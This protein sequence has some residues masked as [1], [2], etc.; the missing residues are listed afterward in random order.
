MRTSVLATVL[1]DER[2]TVD[3][4]AQCLKKTTDEWKI[5]EQILAV[6]HDGAANIKEV[7][8]VN[9]WTDIGCAAHKLHLVVSAALGIDKVTNTPVSKCVA[10]CSRLVGHFSH[11]A[12][13]TSELMKRQKAMDGNKAPTKLIQFCKTRWNSVYDMFQRVVELRWPVTAVLS[14]RNIVKL[15]DAKTLDMRDEHWTLMEELLPILQPLQIATALFSAEESTS[16]S[17]VYPTIMKLI[18][19]EL[20]VKDDDSTAVRTFKVCKFESYRPTCRVML[21]MMMMMTTMTN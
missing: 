11:S 4:I 15:T 13:A 20:A 19:H 18:T 16:A 10:A 6:V 3:Y 9:E 12:L 5:S 17:T 2:H 1:M 8:K 7:G 14:D 21:L